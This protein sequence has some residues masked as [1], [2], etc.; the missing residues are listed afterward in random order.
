MN[1]LLMAV[2]VASLLG[3]MAVG[4]TNQSSPKTT[5]FHFAPQTE[6]SWRTYSNYVAAIQGRDEERSD[7]PNI[8]PKYWTEEIRAL[9]P[10]RVYIHRAN[11]AVVQKVVGDAEEGKYFYIPISSYL[12][13]TGD[14]GFTFVCTNGYLNFTRPMQKTDKSQ[15]GAGT[16]R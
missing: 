7:N 12:P 4:Q 16:L 8:P 3:Q 14:D 9:D 10:I 15:Q 1:K 2:G 13:M 6:G 11:L 5:F